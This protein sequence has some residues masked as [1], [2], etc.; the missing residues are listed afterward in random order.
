MKVTLTTNALWPIRAMGRQ[1]CVCLVLALLALPQPAGAQDLPPDSRSLL[2]AAWSE[3]LRFAIDLSSR[4]IY[5]SASDEWHQVN[6]IGTDL[7][8]VFS[9]DSGDIGTLI[10]QGYFTHIEDE[11]IR[12]GAFDD[13]WTYVYRIVNFN[14]SLLPRGR[15]NLRLGHF[16]IP[17]GLEHPIDTNGTVRDYTHGRN[18]GLKADWG[19]SLNGILSGAE[20]EISIT[21]GSGNSWETE[22]D[23]YIAAGRIGTPAYRNVVW[24]VSALSGDVF[25]HGNPGQTIEQ[26]RVGADAQW[27]VDQ[28]GLLG[29]VSV[30]ERN[31]ERTGIGLVELNRTANS[32]A[33]MAYLQWIYSTLDPDDRDRQ[34]ASTVLLGAKWDMTR[35]D[36][37][38]QLSH[39][40]DSF[41]GN[42]G[43]NLYVAQAR[44]RF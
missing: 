34:D 12:P 36:L 38:V 18:I 42:S 16:E 37:S 21:R 40:L 19:A 43:K 5:S 10:L 13:E 39:D 33:W 25:D 3:N 11:E 35:W 6:F 4:Q 23:P 17:I 24:G 44:Y 32:G 7:H 28:F 29:E 22:G 2:P 1:A 30:G 8:K 9:G 31:G 27:Y 26:K 41:D 20:Y 14:Y 15:M